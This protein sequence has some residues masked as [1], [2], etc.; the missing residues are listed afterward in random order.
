GVI[1]SGC[2]RHMT[3]NMSYLSDFQELNDGYVAFGG[4]S[5]GGKISSKGKIKTSNL[6][7]GLPTKVFENNNTCVACK[8]GKQHRAS[9]K[10]KPISSVNQPLFRLHIDLFGPTFVKSLNKKSYC[11]VI[12]DDYSRFTWVFFL[13]TKDETSPILKT[14]ITSLENQLSLKVKVIRS[15][16]GTK[17]KNS[18]LNQFC[19]L[20]GI[21]R[22]FSVPRTPQQ[23]GIAKRKNRTLI[24]AARTMLAD[25]LLPIQFWADAV[26]TACYV[27]NRVL[28]TKPH[29]KT[30]YEL[31]HG[32]TPSI[33]FTRPFGCPVTI[34]N[35]LD[36]LGKFERKADEGFL[37]GYSVNSKA[38]RVF[39]SRTWKEATQQYMNFPVWSTGSLNPQ[40][41]EGDDA[42]N[43]KEHDAEKSESAV[44]LSP[45]SSALSGEQ[46]DMT[47]KQD[48]GKSHVE[49]FIGNRD[50]NVDFEDYSEDSNNN[51]S[52]AGLIVP[53]A[54]Q[55]YSNST[56]PI[57]AA[58]PSNTNTSP[59]HG[60]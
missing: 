1:D 56:N 60:K 4:N 34:L 24:E 38:F 29:N 2:S 13:A 20:K 58:G 14:F 26:N 6:V 18:D 17:F 50:F 36:P 44:N 57:S 45:S 48:K 35:T 33:G 7:R 59:T 15:D 12:T 25:S 46:D 9:C 40:N 47:K 52:A 53:T 16:N 39:N 51:V 54:G 43:G 30:P 27:Q 22:E 21:K 8:K 32:R 41:K 37:V 19:E 42:F 11:L 3:G 5:K 49:Y 10:A 31:L 28:V 55:N 23:N